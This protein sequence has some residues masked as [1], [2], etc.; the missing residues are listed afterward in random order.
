M[1]L[2]DMML[3]SNPHAFCLARIYFPIQQSQIKKFF[4]PVFRNLLAFP[5]VILNALL[6][7]LQ[8]ARPHPQVLSA[9]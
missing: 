3:T 4:F 6:D 1:E 8:S 9:C 5:P 7:S 2:G